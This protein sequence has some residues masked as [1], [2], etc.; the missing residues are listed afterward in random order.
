M[1]AKTTRTVQ[2]TKVHALLQRLAIEPITLR[3]EKFVSCRALT[4]RTA[5]PRD[6][7]SS[8]NETRYTP[9]DSSVKVSPL[10]AFKPAT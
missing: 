4:N 7:G 2:R 5:R 6:F 3:P 1:I 8:D 9:V 10:Q